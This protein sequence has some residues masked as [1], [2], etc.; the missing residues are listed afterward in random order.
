MPMGLEVTEISQVK[1]C[2]LYCRDVKKLVKPC[3]RALGGKSSDCPG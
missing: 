2:L 3:L 1:N